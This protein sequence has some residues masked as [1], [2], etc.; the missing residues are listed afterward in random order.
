MN[1]PFLTAREN[2]GIFVSYRRADT[3]GYAGRLVD[4]LKS[5]FGQQVFFDVDSISPGANFHQVIQETFAKC[6]AVVILIG[7]KWLER[8]PAMPPFGDEKD[9]ITQEVRFALEA[10]LPIL[11]VLVDG[12]PM[13]GETALPA[14]FAGISRLNAIDLRH[15]SFDRDV[16]AVREHLGEILGA[17]KATKIEKGFL[18]IF[19]PYFGSSF[20][21]ISGGIVGFAVFGAAWALVEMIAA[22]IAIGQ[23]GLRGLFTASLMDPEMLRLQAAW[24]A[25][26]GGVLFGFMG[27][28]SL[29]W[30]RHST[31]AMWFSVAEIIIAA[32]LAFAYVVQVPEARIGDLFESKKIVAA[33]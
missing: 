11:P 9:V 33:P 28:R 8:D 27:R 1:L 6:G 4:H 23:Q 13:P 18:R 7:K 3:A 16:E 25:A 26:L 31:V 10:R 30:W 24:T 29:R 19:G 15:T 17:A 14:E 2:V 32:G 22:A 12:A 21:R 5:H 20:A